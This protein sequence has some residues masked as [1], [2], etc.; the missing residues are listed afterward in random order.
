M[1]TLL[2][3]GVVGARGIG[4]FIVPFVWV[5]L[6]F[7]QWLLLALMGIFACLGHLFPNPIPQVCRCIQIGTFCLFRDYY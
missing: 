6:T 5:N 4:T 2:L 3:T 7:N 1:L